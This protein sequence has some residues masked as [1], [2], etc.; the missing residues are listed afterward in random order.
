M[1]EPLIILAFMFGLVVAS[2]A[3]FI[4][5][6]AANVAEFLPVQERRATGTWLVQSS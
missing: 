4:E 2:P 5:P 3:E 1:N 6:V